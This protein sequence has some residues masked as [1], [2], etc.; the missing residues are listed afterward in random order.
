MAVPATP[1]PARRT[2]IYGPRKV[3]FS[4]TNSTTM[5]PT[6]EVTSRSLNFI[7]VKVISLE[8]KCARSDDF[9][10]R[11][12]HG[13]ASVHGPPSGSPR[14][15]SVDV[16]VNWAP[17]PR[18]KAAGRVGHRFTHGII[19]GQARHLV[20]RGKEHRQRSRGQ[21]SGG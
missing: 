18:E 3:P 12:S 19:L 5:K 17:V 10:R 16:F 1:L 13:S 8:M 7:L 15:Q 9:G 20:T 11:T 14:R 4:F 2:N 6:R 21:L